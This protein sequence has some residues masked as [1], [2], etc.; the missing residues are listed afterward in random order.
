MVDYGLRVHVFSGAFCMRRKVLQLQW[1]RKRL[2][3]R[4]L[5][6]RWRLGLACS[7]LKFVKVLADFIR[8]ASGFASSSYSFKR[9]GS[10]PECYLV[11]SLNLP[12]S[13]DARLGVGLQP[14]QCRI[15]WQELFRE[16]AFS[17]ILQ[18]EQVARPDPCRTGQLGCSLKK[19]TCR[20]L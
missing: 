17:L 13:F 12:P 4:F 9:N 15:D 16:N 5:P 19:K 6:Y 18:G 3:L 10:Q 8:S 11:T 7:W 1:Q 2:I 14:R 20:N